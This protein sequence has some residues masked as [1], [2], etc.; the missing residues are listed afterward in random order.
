MRS[1]SIELILYLGL[2]PLGSSS[3]VV[4]FYLGCLPLRSSS[5][6]V[7]WFGMVF[8]PIPITS[9]SRA[10]YIFFLTLWDNSYSDTFSIFFSMMDETPQ[11]EQHLDPS[12]QSLELAL[13]NCQATPFTRPRPDA[14]SS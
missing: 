1:S 14:T 6:D 5:I 9:V 8:V 10:K 7:F 11:A 13:T 12:C 3:I 4:V 2:L